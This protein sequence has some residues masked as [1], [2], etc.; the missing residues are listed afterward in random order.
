MCMC[1]PWYYLKLTK[2]GFYV[3]NLTFFFIHI[4]LLHL[5]IIYFGVYA[6]LSFLHEFV[7][8]FYFILCKSYQYFNQL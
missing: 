1:A 5:Y 8:L 4:K 3:I 7:S 2:S 6:L